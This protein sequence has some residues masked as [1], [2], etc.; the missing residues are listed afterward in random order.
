MREILEIHDRITSSSSP[1]PVRESNTRVVITSRDMAT[2]TEPNI[3]TD[4]P[5]R[6]TEFEC[7]VDY[8]ERALT[9]HERRL[10]VFEVWQDR[11]ERRVEGLDAEY[12]NDNNALKIAHVKLEAE[13][14]SLRDLV[15]NLRDQVKENGCKCA[16]CTVPKGTQPQRGACNMPTNAPMIPGDVERVS[17]CCEPLRSA[18]PR[19]AESAALMNL[20]PSADEAERASI[21]LPMKINKEPMK[22]QPGRDSDRAVSTYET[23]MKT[24]SKVVPQNFPSGSTQRT[25][26]NNNLKQGSGALPQR[27]LRR[28]RPKGPPPKSQSEAS[29]ERQ[30]GGA[31]S[32]P[33]ANISWADLENE[34]NAI[35]EFIAS[36]II[37][38]GVCVEPSND[39]PAQLQR[40]EG[41]AHARPAPPPVIPAN[42]AP[43]KNYANPKNVCMNNFPSYSGAKDFLKDTPANGN[44]PIPSKGVGRKHNG[45]SS[46]IPPQRGGGAR[47]KVRKDHSDKNAVQGANDGACGSIWDLPK[48]PSSPNEND[49]NRSY[50]KMVTKNGWNT[51]PPS[52]RKR[53][54]SG[55]KNLPT[56]RGV[57][58]K[59]TR[60]VYVRGLASADFKTPEDMEEAVK[61]YCRERGVNIN[62]ARV[63]TN[64]YGSSVGVRVNVR[65]ED[66]ETLLDPIFWPSDVE[67]REWLP[68]GRER[69]PSRTFYN[70]RDDSD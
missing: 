52:K 21:C 33:K 2:Q 9:D 55:A 63:I 57:Q 50:A 20:P 1:K 8:L 34:D 12:Y 19:R 10:R 65:E 37:Q 23:F 28:T 66:Y 48:E 61:L 44:A 68:R 42:T 45:A 31:T 32:T 69:K 67:V 35:D 27:P 40:A 46:M 47:E 6:R 59:R 53:E 14:E 43:P 70:R 41:N 3:L 16:C 24:A 26:D 5:V 60:D 36:V 25:D 18:Q 4:S 56:L 39:K 17:A 29:T 7:Q 15:K 54:K 62:F 11:I 22:Q 30:T 51:V 38:D 58:P 64:A 49:S 13:A